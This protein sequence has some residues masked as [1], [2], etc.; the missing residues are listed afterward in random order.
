MLLGKQAKVNLPNNNGDTPL[1]AACLGGHD[2]VVRE[3]L[4]SDADVTRSNNEGMTPIVAA[5]ASGSEAVVRCL[6]NRSSSKQSKP[7]EKDQLSRALTVARQSGHISLANLLLN[8]MKRDLEQARD[9]EPPATREKVDVFACNQQTLYAQQQTSLW[10]ALKEA[11][12][13]IS[14]PPF[15]R[16]Q[17]GMHLKLPGKEYE[18]PVYGLRIPKAIMALF[19]MDGVKQLADQIR[20]SLPT[21]TI[22]KAVQA[23]MHKVHTLVAEA[24]KRDDCKTG[25]NAEAVLRLERFATEFAALSASSI[26]SPE[27]WDQ[28]VSG[29]TAPGW[30]DKL[31]FSALLPNF[32]FDQ[33]AAT[34]LQTT[35]IGDPQDDGTVKMV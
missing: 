10:L 28:W 1:L 5:A 32:G 29:H 34:A 6:L 19:E 7:A 4:Q 8:A 27:A 12:W 31:E 26:T 17:A 2:S 13:K 21:Y 23:K 25:R 14:M 30:M 3:L 20:V 35:K 15:N 33:P 18:L 16:P 22:S 24:R 11:N 9:G